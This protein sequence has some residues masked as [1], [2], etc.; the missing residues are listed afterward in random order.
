MQLIKMMPV[1][2][3][4][5]INL[6]VDISHCIVPRSI[7]N[8]MRCIFVAFLVAVLTEKCLTS[9]IRINVYL[10]ISLAALFVLI[11]N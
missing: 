6:A 1:S 4:S 2:G 8:F 3:F 5:S 10:Y 9:L 7:Y 11:R